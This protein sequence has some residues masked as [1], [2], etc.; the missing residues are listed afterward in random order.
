ML[1][2]RPGQFSDA[3]ANTVIVPVWAADELLVAGADELAGPVA[4][5]DEL[6]LE[7]PATAM[8]AAAAMAKARRRM[9]TP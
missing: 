6:L 8:A 7:Q 9:L 2:F 5:L 3:A 1:C 4:V